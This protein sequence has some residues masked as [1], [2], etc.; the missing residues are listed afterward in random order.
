M[1]PKEYLARSAAIK[2]REAT[3]RQQIESAV[4]RGMRRNNPI[5]RNL[6]MNHQKIIDELAVL[7]AKFLN[8][9]SRQPSK[10]SP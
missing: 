8:P 2:H 10:L 7:D 4:A 1:T 6:V 5:L 9:P 3:V